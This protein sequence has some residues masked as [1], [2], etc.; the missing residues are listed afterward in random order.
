VRTVSGVPAVA[1]VPGVFG[2]S[3]E[4]GEVFPVPGMRIVGVGRWALGE[5]GVIVSGRCRWGVSVVRV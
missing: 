4:V 2:G 5:G 3:A 1:T